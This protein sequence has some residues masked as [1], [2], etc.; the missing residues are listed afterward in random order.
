MPATRSSGTSGP[1]LRRLVPGACSEGLR[2]GFAPR[3]AAGAAWL[4]SLVS[5]AAPGLV[6]VHSE[7]LDELDELASRFF[8]E[9]V[10]PLLERHCFEC[11]GGEE[12]LRGEFRI[13][14]RE[15]LLAGGALGA[16]FSEEDPAASLLLAMVSYRDEHHQMP[17]SGKLDE[18]SLAVLQEWIERGAPY[19]PELEIRGEVRE[20]RGFT[21]TEGDREWWAYRPLDRSAPPEEGAAGE[22]TE[23]RWTRNPIDRFVAAQLQR[24]GL[25]P[26]PP[27]EA[28][29]LVRRM[30]YGLLGL[31]PRPEEVDAFVS[32]YLEDADGAVAALVDK[33]LARPQYG[34]KWARHWLDLVRYAES[35]GFERDNPKPHIWRYRDYVVDAFNADKPYDLFVIEQLAGDEIEEPTLET[36]AA[37]GYHRLMQWDD[38]PADR[39]QHVYDVLA[40]NAQV[41]SEAFL[42]TTLGCARCHD[43]KVD[44]LSQKDFFAFLAHFAG[45]THYE[46]EGTLV[47]WASEEEKA[48]F[49][50]E[51]RADVARLEGRRT[52]LGEELSEHL[53]VAGAL[54]GTEQA[55]TLLPSG[56][57]SDAD[58]WFYV[59]EAPGED[60]RDIGY[61]NKSWHRGR[62][63]FGLAAETDEAEGAAGAGPLRTPWEGEGIWM[64]SSFR[65]ASIPE[66]LLLEIAHGESVAVY[67]NGGLVYES[68]GASE[69]SEALVLGEEARALLQTGQNALAVHA[70]HPAGEPRRL[71]LALRTAAPSANLDALLTGDRLAELRKQVREALDRDLVHEYQEARRALERRRAEQAGIPL[72]V[73]TERG[74][75]PPAMHLHLRGSAHAL[76]EEVAPGIPAVL[77][78]TGS[79]PLPTRA[80][81]VERQG[82]ASSGRRLALAHWI[83]SPDNALAARVA[84]NRVWQHHFGRGIVE[85]SS[86][87]GKLGEEPTHPDLLDWLAGMFVEEGWSLKALH[88]RI[89]LS[90]TY[91]LS[92]AP[93]SGN[94][95]SDPNN[96]HLWRFPM[97]RLTAEELRDSMLAVSGR[98]NL[99]PHGEWVYPPLPPEVLATA[100]RPDRVWPLSPDPSEHVR[101]SLYIHV[102]RSLRYQMLADFDQ[103]E[104]D[105]SC[106]VRFVTTVPTQALAMLNSRFVNEEAAAFARRIGGEGEGGT[107][108]VRDS[109]AL[110]LRLAMQREPRAGELDHLEGLHRRLLDEFGLDREKA[111]QRLALVILNLN[112]FTYLD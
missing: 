39:T 69:G 101:R 41:T 112:E 88:R 95:A 107:R 105:T 86:D 90:E 75:E 43:H 18:A 98:L 31:P 106:A 58:R 52:R 111:M 36:L 15:G 67:L 50:K 99:K 87:F 27:A 103:A 24:E 25:V 23:A 46:T 22:D 71:D 108:E 53:R 92:S 38:E 60:W 57:E 10:H 66:S 45:V 21:V 11:H 65:L 62:A 72:N 20:R 96:R 48:D 81:P 37:T 8:A 17:P 59:V 80:E 14:S 16:A 54:S 1:F 83:A 42:G 76:G 30:H 68:R 5:L 55:V 110:A 91:R 70:T 19:D 100:S 33:L 85:S 2:S 51:R 13:T 47:H 12:R 89:L 63:G 93:E 64:R 73:V 77:A 7:E 97:R 84:V 3:A 109:L 79:E 9:Q 61:S 49:E 102:K 26:N 6:P 32:A 34:E 56:E 78:P 4:A 29:A 104:T 94:L 28:Q 82:R 74:P 44:L 35:N 40:D